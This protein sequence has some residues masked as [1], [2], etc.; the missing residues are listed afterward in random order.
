M[1]SLDKN[2]AKFQEQLA[3]L[4]EDELI[5]VHM[6]HTELKNLADVVEFANWVPKE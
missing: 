3:E 2:E 1:E 6:A 4:P 5:L